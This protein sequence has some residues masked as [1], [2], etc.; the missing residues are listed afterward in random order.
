MN[1]S[2][3]DGIA[4]AILENREYSNLNDLHLWSR[5]VVSRHYDYNYV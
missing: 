3:N 5:C 4:I 1:Y 2:D